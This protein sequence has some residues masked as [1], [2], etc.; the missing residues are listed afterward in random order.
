[1]T[2]VREGMEKEKNN[3]RKTQ[4]SVNLK[5]N[6]SKVESGVNL[7]WFVEKKTWWV[8]K[9]KLVPR[10]FRQTQADSGTP[11]AQTL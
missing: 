6:P 8:Q 10:S 5:K 2:E 3:S 9:P 1:M 4:K 7:P 11:Q